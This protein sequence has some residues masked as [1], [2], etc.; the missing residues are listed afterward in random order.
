MQRKHIPG[1]KL[2]FSSY[3]VTLNL[4]KLCGFVALHPGS[5]HIGGDHRLRSQTPLDQI[6]AL[7]MFDF[8]AV[9]RSF[10]FPKPQFLHLYNQDK[11]GSSYFTELW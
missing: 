11:S 9:G 7:P 5:L 10:N 8:R 4:D 2:P 3:S 6:P 1:L